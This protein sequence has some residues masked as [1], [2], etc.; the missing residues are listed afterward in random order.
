[1]KFGVNEGFCLHIHCSGKE[2]GWDGALM[3]I[4]TQENS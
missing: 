3:F 2:C 4:D 1:M